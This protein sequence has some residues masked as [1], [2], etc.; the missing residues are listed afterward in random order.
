M[1]T[2]VFIL[3]GTLQFESSS[4]IH[5]YSE[6]FH[7]PYVSPSLSEHS[8]HTGSRYQ[9]HMKPPNTKALVDIITEFGW[10]NFHYIYDS[11]DGK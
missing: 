6:T 4:I 7:M 10:R 1:S 2:G 11:D 5:A 9:L 8:P 3:V